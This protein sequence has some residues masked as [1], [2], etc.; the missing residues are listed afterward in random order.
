MQKREDDIARRKR[1]QNAYKKKESGAHF[2]DSLAI[3]AP[4]T[5]HYLIIIFY[6]N[7]L[8][9]LFPEYNHDYSIVA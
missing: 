4:V 9:D 6:F 3:R 7:V 2:D 1:E 5:L 8:F